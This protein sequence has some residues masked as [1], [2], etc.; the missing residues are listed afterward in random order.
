MSP[1][2]LKYLLVGILVFGF[3]VRKTLGFLNVKNP[4]PPIPDTLSEYLNLSKLEESKAYQ[5]ENFRFTL[6]AGIFSFV[7]TFLFIALGWF[8]A[9]D[10]WVAGF[11]FPPLLKSLVFFWIDLHRIGSFE[12]AF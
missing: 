11:G 5:K 9:I 8:G 6:L 7:F 12:L 3:L 2:N 1:E 4:I 10:S